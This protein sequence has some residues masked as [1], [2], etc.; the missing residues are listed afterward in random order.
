[1]LISLKIYGMFLVKLATALA[2]IGGV[3]QHE[4]GVRG[5]IHLLMIGG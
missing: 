4:A 1:M 2:L 5:D 3:R